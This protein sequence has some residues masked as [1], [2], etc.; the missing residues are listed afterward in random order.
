MAKTSFQVSSAPLVITFAPTPPNIL[1]ALLLGGHLCQF[2]GADLNQYSTP[3]ASLA[4]F[5]F[6]HAT[7]LPPTSFADSILNQLIYSPVSVGASFFI[8]TSLNCNAS[9]T[10]AIA[11]SRYRLHIACL[12]KGMTL[13]IVAP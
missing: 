6:D 3:K 11:L 4:S 12:V 7:V 13:T 2:T 8:K 9:L 1:V 5:I 10:H